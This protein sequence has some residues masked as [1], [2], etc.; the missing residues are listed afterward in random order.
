MATLGVVGGHGVRLPLGNGDA[1]ISVHLWGVYELRSRYAPNPNSPGTDASHWAFIFGPS[2][3]IGN[4]G[5]N[6]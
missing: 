1:A 4:V 5:A 2:V 6:L 3:S